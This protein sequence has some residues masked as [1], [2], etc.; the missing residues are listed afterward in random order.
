VTINDFI[1]EIRALFGTIE[2][3]ATSKQGHIFKSRG[4]DEKNNQTYAKKQTR[5]YK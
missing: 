3:K 1:K 2:Y 4:Y 5:S